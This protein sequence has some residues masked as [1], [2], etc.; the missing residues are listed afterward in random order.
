VFT[1]TVSAELPLSAAHL[2]EIQL[3]MVDVI[4]VQGTARSVGTYLTSYNIPAAGK[5]GTA[6]SG[7]RMPHAWFA[8]YTFA[9]RED[10]PDIAVAV[11]I[12]NGGE[13]SLMAAPVFQGMVKYYFYGAPRNTF[14]WEVSPGVLIS[15]S[16]EDPGGELIS[17][18]EP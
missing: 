17:T 9:E 1:P 16:E 12:E 14:P 10:K 6:Q 4:G 7:Q 5:T 3:A 11:V 13:G 8:G 18:P 15:P 2:N